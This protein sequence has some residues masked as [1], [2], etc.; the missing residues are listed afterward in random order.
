VRSEKE[1]R[2]RS[3]FGLAYES[4]RLGTLDRLT[5]RV[6]KFSRRLGAPDPDFVLA[7]AMPP[8]RPKGMH[9]RNYERRSRRLR[10][11]LEAR[12]DAISKLAKR[13]TRFDE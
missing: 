4:Q 5:H 1:I 12:T 13:F 11:V 7:T 8:E 2:C 9:R 10:E 6:V 3:C